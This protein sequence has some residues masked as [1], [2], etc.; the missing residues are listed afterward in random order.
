MEGLNF[1]DSTG[2]QE[3]HEAQLPLLAHREA[4]ML[5]EKLG[6]GV[7]HEG[8]EGKGFLTQLPEKVRKY[9]KVMLL[10]TA[11]SGG[12]GVE[13]SP[14]EAEAGDR[15]EYVV[16]AQ[17]IARDAYT[18][19]RERIARQQAQRDVST[20]QETARQQARA[21]AEFERN[22]NDIAGAAFAKEQARI[23][24]QEAQY[25]RRA[26]EQAG[27][28]AAR[29]QAALAHDPLARVI[30]GLFNLPNKVI[31]PIIDRAFDGR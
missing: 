4:E 26:L 17:D 23:A 13:F 1:E 12:L 10:G 6:E 30:V 8:D 7:T 22:P 20:I 31:S 16:T 28:N 14:T 27:R 18:Q 19:E 25:R 24:A 5:V 11:L 3:S 21:D 29:Q 15:H 2:S 9:A